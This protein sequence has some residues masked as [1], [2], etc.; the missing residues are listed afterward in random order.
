MAYDFGHQL[1]IFLGQT[2]PQPG[3]QT[4]VVGHVA[5][6]TPALTLTKIRRN[7]LRR[8]HRFRQQQDPGRGPFDQGAEG[9][10]DHVDLGQVHAARA[11]CFPQVGR[12]I[13]PEH[14]HA[15][16][17]QAQHGQRHLGK[18]LGVGVIQIP[19][20][21][22]KRGPDPGVQRG[23]VGEIPWRGFGEDLPQ[24][25]FP[26]LHGGLVVHHMEIGAP[27][28]I[29]AARCLRPGVVIA[30]MVEHEVRAQ[31]DAGAAQ[32]GRQGTQIVHAAQTRLDLVKAGD[33]KPAV[34]VA[35]AGSQE[36]KQMQQRDAQLLQIRNLG[37][38]LGQRAG[39][40]V[41]IGC[42]TQRLVR[43]E[44]IGLVQAKAVQRLEFGRSQRHFAHHPGG[45]RIEPLIEIRTA[46]IQ[47]MQLGAQCLLL[48]GLPNRPD[49]VCSVGQV[50][51]GM[52]S[53]EI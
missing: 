9:L 27:L 53:H 37:R 46:A 2:G 47:L 1:G 51:H 48:P 8:D 26:A 28:C 40:A 22:V 6:A 10:Q 12:G 42:V 15:R 18:H 4:A 36:R 29:P 31:A 50:D 45:Q 49:A 30:D 25:G 43:S 5:F 34:A 21:R 32:R 23:V 11:L 38:K 20:E 44:P 19:L 35:G 39:K 17:G 52:F 41:N 13:Q 7:V 16:I 3:H 24:A 14:L 33:G